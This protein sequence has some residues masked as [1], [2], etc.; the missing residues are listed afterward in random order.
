[1]TF[2]PA[3]VCSSYRGCEKTFV[4]PKPRVNFIPR[5]GR[6]LA[7]FPGPAQLSVAIST[8]KQATKSW[9]GPGNEARRALLYRKRV[10]GQEGRWK[11]N[12]FMRLK[13]WIL[14]DRCMQHGAAWSSATGISRQLSYAGKWTP[15]EPFC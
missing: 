12:P 15:D 4:I 8:V 2:I 11:R 3:A 13:F 10:K 9:A 5:S 6:A 14:D 7:S 1:M